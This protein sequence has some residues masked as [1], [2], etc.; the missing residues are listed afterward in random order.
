[1]LIPSHRH[2]AAD[3]RLWAEYERADVAHAQSPAFRAKYDAAAEAVSA[4]AI[5][6]PCYCAVS[7]G[8]D[9]VVLAHLVSSY[10]NRH[11]DHFSVPFVWVTVGELDAGCRDV[12]DAFFALWPQPYCELAVEPGVRTDKGTKGKRVGFRE[13]E[14]RFGKRRLIG[15]RADESSGRRISARHWGVESLRACRPLLWWTAQDVFACLAFFGLPVHPNYAML[16]GGRW[17]REHL[18]TAPLGG[19][20]GEQFGRTEW[21]REYYGDVLRRLEA[22]A[23]PSPNIAHPRPAPPLLTR[24]RGR[25]SLGSSRR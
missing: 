18:R 23:L 21:E 10:N 6:K 8:K 2:T 19:L 20:R 15:I 22:S 17:E 4:F 13:A 7:W 12:R 25:G 14:R 1:M 5:A 3:L 9:S 24:A 11:G 16:G